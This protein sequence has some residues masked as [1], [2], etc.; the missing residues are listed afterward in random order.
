MPD[1]IAKDKLE[2]ALT[3]ELETSSEKAD[4]VA[5]PTGEAKLPAKVKVGD[6]DF[7]PDEL[8]KLVA[9][10]KQAADIEREQNIDIKELYPDYTRK[11]QLLK[12]PEKLKD[13]MS[14]QLGEAPKQQNGGA[15][16]DGGEIPDEVMKEIAKARKLGFL[17]KEDI[18][19]IVDKAVN[20]ATVRT[21]A[22]IRLENRLAELE[23]KYDGGDQAPVKIK[24]N[25]DEILNHLIENYR[26]AKQVPDP[27]DVF[28]LMHLE[29]FQKTAQKTVPVVANPPVTEK[30]GSTGSRAP[31]GREVP[32]FSNEDTLKKYLEEEFS[33]GQI[34]V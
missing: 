4:E 23:E 13:Y 27:E 5:E 20:V 1:T 11:S 24:F 3:E 25:R 16:N 29:D 21:K 34:E 15:S 30:A 7:D 8:A 10:G 26:G 9:K 12:N 33:K 31:K 22:E 19:Q 14:S 17:T 28:K 18:D 32:N 2:D 6:Q